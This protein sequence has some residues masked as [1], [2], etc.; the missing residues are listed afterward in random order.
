MNFTRNKTRTDK[1]IKNFNDKRDE[2]CVVTK[3]QKD[4]VVCEI[5]VMVKDFSE[6]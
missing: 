5:S 6:P 2:N 3:V 4:K 1:V